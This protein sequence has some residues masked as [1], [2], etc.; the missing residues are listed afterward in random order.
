MKKSIL[1]NFAIASSLLIAFAMIFAMAFGVFDAHIFAPIGAS[2]AQESIA[3]AASSDSYYSSVENLTTTGSEFRK[4]LA[5]LITSTHKNYT[6]YDG[7]ASVYKKSD[8]DP[9]KSGNIIWFYTGTSVSFSSFD[10]AVSGTNREHVWPKNS[11]KAFPKSSGPGS[12]AHHLRP[13]NTGL[14]STRSSKQFGEVA[15][16]AGNIVK[17]NNSTSYDNLCYS[18]GNY[19]YPGVGY[20]G[21]TARILMYMQ[22]RWG[23]QYSLQFVL[24]AGSSK[25]IG[26]IKTLMKWHLEEPVTQEEITRNEAVYKEQGN[27]N[28]FIDH[29]EYAEKIFCYDGQSYNNTLQEVVATYGSSYS[30]PITKLTLGSSQSLAVGE[31]TT[32]TASYEPSNAKRDVTWTS[33]NPSVATVD[34]YGKVTAVAQGTTTIT[35]ASKEDSSIKATTTIT[36]AS[37][38][39]IEISGSASVTEYQSGDAFNPSGL[40]V[41]AVYS[42]NTKRDVTSSCSWLDGTTKESTLSVGTTSIVCKYS[43]FEKNLENI[44]TVTAQTGDTVSLSRAS[45]SSSSGGYE[46]YNWKTDAVDGKVFCYTGNQDTIQMNSSKSKTYIYNTT[47]ISNLKSITIT[48]SQGNSAQFEILTSSSDVFSVADGKY[49][50]STLGTSHGTQTATIDGTTWTFNTTDKY[51]SINYTGSGAVYIDSIEIT[52]GDEIIDGGNTGTEDGNAGNNT[53]NNTG[54]SGNTD[55]GGNTGDGNTDIG[56]NT[57]NDG[58]N[59]GDG[60]NTG[61]EDKPNIEGNVTVA[62]FKAAVE[63]IKSATTLEEKKQAIE[64]AESLFNS[65]PKGTSTSHDVVESYKELYNQRNELEQTIK[66]NEARNKDVSTADIAGI[67]VFAGFAIIAIAVLVIAS[68]KRKNIA[69]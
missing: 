32:L 6:S 5:T 53:G 64:Y 62:E 47:P 16:T 10:G 12:D 25:T 20:R 54:D 65:L 31:T 8:A 23:D 17:E 59:T 41:N 55:I 33:S 39:G 13:L 35:V 27:R 67:L 42:N 37:V 58:D 15:T 63:A 4:S 61:T 46:W 1:R 28:P 22:V 69:K 30:E 7:L 21:A 11:G 45:I 50:T 43:T 68:K 66:A 3:E 9:N 26:D 14:N 29:P 18:S 36:V 51:F 57:G 48:I 40:T 49:P 19:F 52:Y 60:N 24:G 34:A 56:D 44:I 2:Y 38:T